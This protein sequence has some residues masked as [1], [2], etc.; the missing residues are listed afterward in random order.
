MKKNH[1]K[2]NLYNIYDWGGYIMWR[3]YPQYKVF[4][5]GRGPDVYSMDIW[6]DYRK[7]EKGEGNYH[8]ILD[9][10]E[11]EIILISTAD[12]MKNL[13]QKL[14]EDLRWSLVFSNLATRLYLKKNGLNATFVDIKKRI[15]EFWK[16]LERAPEKSR[17]MMENIVQQY[18]DNPQ[19]YFHLGIYF[20][21]RDKDY[22]RA[23]RMFEKAIELDP[24]LVEAYNNLAVVYEILNKNQKALETLL[25]GLKVDPHSKILQ[26]NLRLLRSKMALKSISR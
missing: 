17:E 2:G 4:I 5:D 22:E 19:G 6:Q 12:I 9:K 13:I 20:G 3:A 11:V 21:K 10:Y 18:P 23:V 16:N 15:D 1:L 25:R 26:E 14:D 7:V 8:Q 24:S